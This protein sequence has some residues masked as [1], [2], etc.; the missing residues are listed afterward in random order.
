MRFPTCAALVLF[1][2]V[3][4]GCGLN[5]ELA[6]KADAVVAATR[7][8]EVACAEPDRCAIASPWH[9]LADEARATSTADKPVHYVDLLETGEDSLLLRVHLIRA[10]RKSIDIQTFIWAGDDSGWLVL[11]ELIA[12]AKRGVHVR[13]IV[14]QLFSLDDVGWLAR[15]AAMHTNI[16][17]RLYNP[18]FD[19]AVTQPLEFAAGIVCCFSSFNQRM[20]NKLFL[21]DGEDTVSLV[22]YRVRGRYYVVDRIFDAAEL[23]LGAKKQAVVRITR[24]VEGQKKSH[25]RRR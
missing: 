8:S 17:F 6:R 3:A 2:L 25:D 7:P 23:R 9:A 22:N 5:R 12:A 21:V 1:A 20:H 4:S 10:A 15:I 16:E 19:K 24:T 11:D 13:V 14:D 18:T